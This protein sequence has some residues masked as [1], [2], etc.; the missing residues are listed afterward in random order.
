MNLVIDNL[1]TTFIATNPVF[2]A[3]QMLHETDT[4]RYKTADG[5][6]TYT[7]LTY[8][9]WGYEIVEAAGTDTY[10]GTFKTPL[11]VSIFAMQRLRVRFANANTGAAT[12]NLN[13]VG[14]V[15]IKKNVVTALAVGD[16]VAGGIYDIVY[17]GTNY[18][19]IGSNGTGGGGGEDLAATLAIGQN[20][21]PWDILIND[22]PRSWYQ[23]DAG[24]TYS[25][26]IYWS[27]AAGGLS[28]GASNL[29]AGTGTTLTFLP[30]LTTIEGT[31]PLF[32]GAQYIADYS[33]N[34]TARSLIDKGYAALT[35]QPIGSYQPLGNELTA[36]QALADTAGFLKKTG[37]GAYSIDTNTYLTSVTAHN[38]LSATHG[39]TT[40]AACVRGDI[41]RGS[42]TAKWEKLAKGATGKFLTTDAT[43][44]IWSTATLPTTATGT[45]TILRADGTNWVAT[46]NTY[47][48]TTPIGQ[49]LYATAANVIGS[50]A[51]L[52]YDGTHFGVG[53]APAAPY[54]INAS[55]SINGSAV[56][57][58][59]NSNAGAAA[60]AQIQ[61]YNGTTYLS[62]TQLGESYT[63]SGMSIA[64]TAAIRSNSVVGLNIGTIVSSP[65]GIWTNNTQKISIPSAGGL[66]IGTAALATTATD[67]FLYI[68]T[69]AGTPTGVPTAQTGTV[70]M[71]FDTTNN[72]LYIYDGGW[73]G[74]TA[75]GAWS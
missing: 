54:V 59:L 47:P 33:A 36:L 18:Q 75:P 61:I 68:P 7:Q 72:K 51:G 23:V 28:M 40:A 6:S 57:N 34:Y 10:T 66:V 20:T 50:G 46:T 63:T 64:K 70:A 55:K 19:I 38:L 58:V 2:K 32:A 12:L 62:I 41:I 8:L 13:S 29:T 31:D 71:I 45:G 39:D 30:N 69:C 9:E 14:A 42:A 27:Q 16:I 15:S 67:G 26:F 35:F 44:T 73:I 48:N 37:D 49:V 24:A 25:N 22:S 53:V 1:S 65:F 11:F 74:G 4:N 56:I 60:N 5:V 52:A 21:G 17:D 3:G 43:D